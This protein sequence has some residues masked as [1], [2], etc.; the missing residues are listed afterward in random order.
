MQTL[1]QVLAALLASAFALSGAAKLAQVEVIEASAR[2]LGI[3][4]RLHATAGALEI[5]AATGIIAGFWLPPL[6]LAATLGLAVMMGIAVR[7]HVQA[8]D[9]PA[10]TAA[11]ALLGILSLTTAVFSIL[12]EI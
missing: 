12:T 6:R 9:R 1:T 10:N 4:P 7:Y 8:N 3:P 2:S 11:P 5:A